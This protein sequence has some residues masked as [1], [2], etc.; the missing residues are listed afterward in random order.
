MNNCILLPKRGGTLWPIQIFMHY[1]WTSGRCLHTFVQL[2]MPYLNFEYTKTNILWEVVLATILQLRC[3]L[4]ILG[5]NFF[6]SYY[7]F[8]MMG[9]SIL[10]ASPDL[11]FLVL[12][13]AFLF[14]LCGYFNISQP[15]MTYQGRIIHVW[16]NK[17]PANLRWMV[18]A[19]LGKIFEK[20]KKCINN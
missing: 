19:K 12:G 1:R 16:L 10:I 5:S 9:H 11:C 14:C 13:F 15:P 17:R 18:V 8:K 3:T 20:W 4:P 7:L 6:K 2:F